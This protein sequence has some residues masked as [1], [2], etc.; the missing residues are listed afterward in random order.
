[1]IKISLSRDEI[2]EAIIAFAQ[3]KIL[4][5]SL[6][7]ENTIKVSQ[8]KSASATILVVPNG[9]SEADAASA[10]SAEDKAVETAAGQP[11]VTVAPTVNT[12]G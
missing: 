10:V 8:G 6:L 4:D 9:T 3:S 2:E 11:D 7:R 12:F 1:M 5:A